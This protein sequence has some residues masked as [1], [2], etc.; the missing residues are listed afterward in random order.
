MCI[1]D[2]RR[3]RVWMVC[4]RKFQAKSRRTGLHIEEQDSPQLL[5]AAAAAAAAAL[6]MVHRRN[7]SST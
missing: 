1:G 4:R 2:K 7:A 5:V 6:A 3:G